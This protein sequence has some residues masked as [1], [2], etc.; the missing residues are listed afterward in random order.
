MIPQL[1]YGPYVP[2]EEH[3]K[4]IGNV[5][6][7]QC[8]DLGCGMG[9]NA[10]ALAE[11]L[12]NV[13]GV[14]I[15]SDCLREA[16]AHAA[17][18]RVDGVYWRKADINNWL[19]D[20]PPAS[21]DLLLA[22]NSLPYLDDPEATLKAA[23]LVLK[24]DGRLVLAQDHPLNTITYHDGHRL[25]VR[26]SYFD[27]GVERWTSPSGNHM[28]W[29]NE[30]LSAWHRM[31]RQAGFAVDSMHEPEPVAEERY[32]SDSDFKKLSMMPATI[33]WVCKKQ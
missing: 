22:C 14:D 3:L 4:L 24:Y 7:L 15:D 16:E 26:R 6:G 20:Q 23:H 1:R 12:G 28:L 32:T 2:G 13:V 10:I 18:T 5:A 31:F 21:F 9:D 33:I 30:P 17:V 25:A 29:R 19:S 27:Q 11:A 8:A